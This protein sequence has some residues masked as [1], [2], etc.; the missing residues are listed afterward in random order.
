MRVG[1][2]DEALCGDAYPRCISG[3]NLLGVR[4]VE[5]ALSQLS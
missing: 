3:L 4:L 2:A 5:A 1:R